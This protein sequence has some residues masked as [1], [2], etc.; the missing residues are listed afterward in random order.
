MKCKD[1]DELATVRG[2]C[3]KHYNRA[4]SKEYVMAHKEAHALACKRWKQ[5]NKDKVKATKAKSK[6]LYP[7]K[8][9]RWTREWFAKNPGKRVVYEANRRAKKIANGGELSI[10]LRARLMKLQ[11][12]KCG[13]CRIVFV[14]SPHLDHMMPL[15]LGGKHVDSNMQ[16]LCSL[17]NR[18]KHAKHPVA[19]MQERG[20]LL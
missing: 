16:L 2:W 10:D 12:G 14:K 17:C 8:W 20:F 9:S 13:C 6:A 18:K 7:D 1:C 11:S 4:Y 5:N 15:A 19:F 3:K